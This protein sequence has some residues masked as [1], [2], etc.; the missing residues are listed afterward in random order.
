MLRLTL[1]FAAALLPLLVAAAAPAP[2]G[3]TGAMKTPAMYFGDDTRMGRPFA[4]DP[5][6]IRL[7]DRYLMYYSTAPSTDKNAPKG[8][9]IGIAESRD[10]LNWKKVGEILPEQPC[11]MNG[12]V[13]GK[14]ILLDG[15]V[16][17]FYNTYGNEKDDALCHATSDDG[18]KFTRDPTNPILRATG[19]WNSGRA[20]DCDA[21]EF[22]GRLILLYATRDPTMKI[23]M[24]AAAA[25][26]RKSDFGRGAWKPLTDGPV[27]KPELP[28]ETQCIEAPSV[29]QRDGTLYL[30]Y[31]GGYNNDP[32][33]IG[34]A[35]SKDGV[36]W[37]RLFQ[38]PLLPN[39]KPGTW[40]S[41]ESG[42]PGIF[43]DEDGQTYLFYQ[44]NNDKGRTWFLS[45]VKIGWKDG[46]PYLLVD[47]LVA[48]LRNPDS[49]VRKQAVADITRLVVSGADR[50][51]VAKAEACA[52]VLKDAVEPL[53]ALA[54]DPEPDFRSGV[55]LAL[56]GIGD[57]R[58]R[59]P[60]L[61]ALKDP[62]PH[63]RAT[64]AWGMALWLNRCGRN[65]TVV[66][67]LLTLMKDSDTDVRG[68]ACSALAVTG[69]PRAMVAVTAAAMK[70]V[71]RQVR[72]DAISA[73]AD[74]KGNEA[75]EALA[76][77]LKDTDWG[78]RACAANAFG[79]SRDPRGVDP[80]IAALKDSEASVRAD[81]ARALG[82]IGDRR[83]LAP[84][85]LAAKDSDPKAAEAAQ[86]AVSDVSPGPGAADRA[87]QVKLQTPISD[88]SFTDDNLKDVFRF[89][90]EVAKIQIDVRWDALAKIGVQP[91]TKVTLKLRNVPL[92]S[93][94]VITLLAAAPDGRAAYVIQDGAVRV[95]TIDDLLK[96][97]SGASSPAPK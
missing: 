14:A 76:A 51:A 49:K 70:D 13:N 60:L 83:A 6:V 57:S 33:Q 10:L 25:A 32:Q 74:V 7:G 91:T 28:W 56:G 96:A 34:V 61:A 8:W 18:L 30:F 45:C 65:P 72:V 82:D 89:F 75:F 93:A 68:F 35:T 59:L 58:A 23:Q 19:S 41:S 79:Q 17:L 1:A 77:C 47:A 50:Q 52:K 64:A 55:I 36:Q 48:G 73:L 97:K 31:G 88:I 78:I 3:E 69:D 39:G 15:K 53:L 85:M 54:K 71:E 94:L 37:T 84:L 29:V 26:D 38:E 24:L 27:M 80:L 81:V 12:L 22:K 11:E 40:N 46:K 87:T 66:A 43:V 20:I 4:K 44:A 86:W 67:P 63:V 21:F 9:A 62:E 92:R 42:H 2:S 95:S 90:Q 16:H 5:C